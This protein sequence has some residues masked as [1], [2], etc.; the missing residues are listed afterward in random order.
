LVRSGEGWYHNDGHNG[1]H[2]GVLFCFFR[3]SQIV[4]AASA[5]FDDWNSIRPS[6]GCDL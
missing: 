5:A 3:W 1:I 2:D 6:V 4:V